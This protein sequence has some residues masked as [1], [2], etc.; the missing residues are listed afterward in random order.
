VRAHRQLQAITHR[1]AP[2]THTLIQDTMTSRAAPAY[3]MALCSWPNSESMRRENRYA[4]ESIVIR[5]FRRA[6]GRVLQ[7][8]DI[9]TDPYYGHASST[10]V[11]IIVRDY[12]FG[13]MWLAIR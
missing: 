11:A 2:A 6:S 1:R 7:A 13:A 9:N 8:Q 4:H 12:K 10:P 3:G 5:S